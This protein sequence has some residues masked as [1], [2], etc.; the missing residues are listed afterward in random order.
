MG[1]TQLRDD[2]IK[3]LLSYKKI[4]TIDQLK[5][6]VDSTSTMT[7]HRTLSRLGYLASYSHR[8]KFYTLNGIPDF[9]DS[10]LWSLG[11]VRFS[12]YGNL[13]QTTASFVQ[14]S[15]EGFT[16]AEL[17][18]LLHV[19]VKHA[20]LQLSKRK[21]LSRYKFEGQFVYTSAEPGERRR[22]EL[23]RDERGA[24]RDLGIG[25]ETELMHD[26]IKAGI[27]LFFSLLDEK[28]RRLYAG[29]EAARLGHGGNRK[30]ADLLGLDPHTVSKGRQELFSGSVKRDG[31][32]NAGA[33][34]KR[35]E[36]KLL[37]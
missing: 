8:G 21:E 33:G 26:E 25:L 30:I 23:M 5:D 19:E 12:Q 20:L 2:S 32:R 37:K 27:I 24:R 6:A 9:D 29:I 3:K 18:S 15:D 22:Q 11:S 13:M 35:I 31:V 7:V 10:G 4:A 14:R 1:D 16:A 36:K 34:R 28:Q 17:E